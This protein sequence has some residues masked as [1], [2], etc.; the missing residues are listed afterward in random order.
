LRDI[1]INTLLTLI[2]FP[3]KTKMKN[4]SCLLVASLLVLGGCAVA[5]THPALQKASLPD[6]IPVHDF[7]ADR[8]S[9]YGYQVS[10]DGKKL[11][12]YG[13]SGARPATFVKPIGGQEQKI[14]N[15]YPR[16]FRWSADSRHLLFVADHGGD[17]NTH[18]YLANVD[19]DGTTLKD[20]TP[21]DKTVAHIRRVV[22][23]GSEIIITDNRRDKKV[24]D[25]YKVDLA[26]GRET[27]LATNPGKVQFWITDRLGN[28]VARVLQDGEKN[29][30]QRKP[31]G[32]EKDWTTIA[33]WSI[34]D[35]VYPLELSADGKWS[36]TISN[37]GRDKSALVKLDLYN[38][39]E[40]VVYADPDADV[41]GA[42]IS[43]LTLQPLTAYSEPDYPNEKFFDP[44]LRAG[45]D[46]LIG[47]K[48]VDIHVISIDDQERRMTVSVGTD[49]G[50]RDYLFDAETAQTTLLGESNLARMKTPLASIKP[51]SFQSRDGVTLHGYLTLPVGAPAEKLPMVLAVHGGPWWR[52]TWVGIAQ[53]SQF[54]A[55]R[56]YAVL[57]INYRGSTGYGR[58]FMEKAIGEFA[59]KMHDDLID[60]VNWAIRSG[61]ADPNKIAI[62]GRSYGG[63]ATLVG[64]TFTPDVFACGAASVAPADLARLI[65][66]VPPYWEL[67][68]PWWH[69]YVGDPANPED[70]KKMDAK[71]PLFKAAAVTKPL[72]IMHGVN[73][74]RV[75]LQQSELMV[76]ALR[77]AGKQVEYVVF[78]DDGHSNRHWT[79]NLTHY[80]KV[81]DFLVG[82]L[83]GRSSGFDYYQLGAWAL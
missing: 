32:A 2:N 47:G 72:L 79:N 58:T 49:H 53:D 34:F 3:S 25:L 9:N 73:D 66:N 63:Y 10:P 69:R 70:R 30:M 71:S 18:I 56:G 59:G 80:R 38:G 54:L 39:D 82:C 42:R 20:L 15:I 13:V 4:I 28:L 22:K 61:V 76:D 21:Y 41:A 46:K 44:H 27:M 7:V 74:V 67:G 11:A 17:E 1:Q 8:Q 50:I 51:I 68:M 40:T 48:P 19:G 52:D 23:G 6:L 60:G 14:F 16:Y 75:K 12:W 83:G 62:Y 37:R 55:N 5:P 31:A 78:P 65:E 64:M 24:F 36:W 81:E 57:R 35:I 43:A 26:T 77:K 33:Q 45:L 29:L